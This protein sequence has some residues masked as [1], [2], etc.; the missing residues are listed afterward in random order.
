MH[1]FSRLLR[2]TP[3]VACL[4]V[5][6]GILLTGCE[7]NVTVKLPEVEQL[8]VVE[9]YV[10]TGQAPYLF[11]SR[12]LDFF[13]S[14]NINTVLENTVSGA[15]VIVDDGITTDTLLQPLPGIG[16]YTSTRLSG[17]PGRTYRLRIFA[18]G[19]ELTAATFLPLPV[20]LDSVW[21]K[22][23]G[24]RDSL[25]FAWA[26]LTEP[27]TIGNNYRWF[28]KRINRYTYGKNAGEVKDSVFLA[29]LGSVFEDKF[30]N[31]RSFDFNVVRGKA[32]NSN[33]EDDLKEENFF[34]KRGDTIAVKFCSIDRAAFQFWRSEETQVSNNGNPF[35]TVTP[36]DGNI[37]GGLGI[38]CAYATTFDTIYAR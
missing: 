27:D 19:T 17:Q 4:Q 11:L 18:E 35:G 9:G 38:W 34:F 7:K 16:Y 37:E 23:D 3:A 10:E 13:G 5:V 29:P 33:K 12:S 2:N 36:V 26:H 21:W 25:G 32:Y 28:A 20:P 22:V 6:I 24:E 31:G 1:H 8:L 30:I 14:V 15:T